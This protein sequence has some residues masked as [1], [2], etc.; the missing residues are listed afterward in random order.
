MEIIW[1]ENYRLYRILQKNIVAWIFYIFLHRIIFYIF[2]FLV[3]A[4][5]PVVCQLLRIQI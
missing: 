4:R 3:D 5:T 1:I 2:Q